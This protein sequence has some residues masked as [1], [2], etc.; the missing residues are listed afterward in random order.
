MSRDEEFASSGSEELRRVLRQWN[1][2]GAPP[3]IEEQLR[4]TFRQRRSRRQRTRWLALAS[5]VVVALAGIYGLSGLRLGSRSLVERSAARPSSAPLPV[6]AGIEP[7]RSESPSQPAAVRPL[8]A[9]HLTTPRRR[10]EPEVIVEPGQAELLRQLAQEWRGARQRP[11][12][13]SVPRLEEIRPEDAPPTRFPDAR[14]ADVPS[15]RT[16]WEPVAGDWLLDR[17][18]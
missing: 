12:G 1:A 2:P 17:A 9:P 10:T 3:E 4:Q 14:A 5:G 13:V 16:I 6:V 18:S 7:T 15:H 8:R 11:P